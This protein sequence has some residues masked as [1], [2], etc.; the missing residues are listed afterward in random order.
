MPGS[1]LGWSGAMDIEQAR[2]AGGWAR[3]EGR[4]MKA[5]PTYCPGEQGQPYRDAWKAGWIATDERM[6]RERK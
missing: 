2:I 1:A 6:K 3:E 4:E 5:C